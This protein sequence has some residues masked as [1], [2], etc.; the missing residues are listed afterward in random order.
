LAVIAAKVLPKIAVIEAL[1]AGIKGLAEGAL[2]TG[3]TLAVV[4]E[5]R[6]RTPEA[7]LPLTQKVLTDI[8]KGIAANMPQST[9]SGGDG[10]TLVFNVHGNI[11]GDKAG[12]RKLAQEVFSYEYS[13]KRRLGGAEA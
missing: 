10:L 2:V 3:P 9:G 8:G 4:G 1:K 7:V 13:I 12:M 11:I 6:D 5:R